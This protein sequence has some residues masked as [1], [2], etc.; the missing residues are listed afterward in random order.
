MM[1]AA[2]SRRDRRAAVPGGA[3]VWPS[4]VSLGD[5]P[6]GFAGRGQATVAALVLVGAGGGELP[7]RLVEDGGAAK[8][9]ANRDTVPGQGVRP[10]ERPPAQLAVGAY[11]SLPS[12]CMLSWVLA[13]VAWSASFR[14]GR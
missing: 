8:A 7:D 12:A 14:P 4:D 6:P 13:A 10:G 9:G 1:A 2:A 11:R 5:H 3:R